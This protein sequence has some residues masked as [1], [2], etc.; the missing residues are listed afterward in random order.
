[1]GQRGVIVSTKAS[2]LQFI[3]GADEIEV[4]DYRL[5]VLRK[6]KLAH[7]FQANMWEAAGLISDFPAGLTQDKEHGVWMIETPEERN[8]LPE[9]Q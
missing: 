1:M 2:S 5:H 9:P 7:V 6:G 3:G 8:G 4:I